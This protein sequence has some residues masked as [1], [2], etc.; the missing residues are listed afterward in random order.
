MKLH[1]AKP[2]LLE[3]RAAKPPPVAAA[4]K[5]IPAEAVGV[6]LKSPHLIQ[7]QQIQHYLKIKK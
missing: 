7:H 3:A 4:A 1:Q 6:V 5:P 2:P